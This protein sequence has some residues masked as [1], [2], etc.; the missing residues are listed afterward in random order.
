MTTAQ[1]VRAVGM[2]LA[3]GAVVAMVSLAVD[4]PGMGPV[5]ALIGVAGVM[6]TLHA[7]GHR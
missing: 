4:G 1:V 6:L 3:L 2:A 7:K 5:F